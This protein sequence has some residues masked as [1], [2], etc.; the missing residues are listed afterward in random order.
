MNI[1]A[2]IPNLLTA[3]NLFSGVLGITFALDAEPVYA[4]YCMIISGI[5]DFFDGFVARLLKVASPI[6]RELDSLADVVT[7]GVLP[8]LLAYKFYTGL[9]EYHSLAAYSL[10]I[11]PI[12]SAYR[13]AIFNLDDKQH[14]HFKGLNTPTN[15]LFI[16]AMICW[17]STENIQ[18][19]LFPIILPAGA[20]I[21]SLLL[22]S[23]IPLLA[24][25]FKKGQGKKEWP[26]IIFLIFSVVSIV[27]LKFAAAAIVLPLYFIF[28]ILYFKINEVHSRN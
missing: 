14:D 28:S 27:F 17:F 20:L 2:Q 11:I 1:K 15:A 10:F 5:F 4:F 24:F 9:P 6:G 16:G 8:G 23:R 21:L 7:F 19:D 25:K 13:L 26:K 12:F 18:W 22:V 3:S